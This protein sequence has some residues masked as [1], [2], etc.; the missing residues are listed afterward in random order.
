MAIKVT[1][2]CDGCYAE[3][4]DYHLSKCLAV[5]TNIVSDG[6]AAELTFRPWSDGLAKNSDRLH[7]HSDMCAKTYL[8][9]WLIK[10]QI[11]ASKREAEAEANQPAESAALHQLVER[12]RSK[13]SIPV[14]DAAMKA[15]EALS[16]FQSKTWTPRPQRF[17]TH[18]RLTTAIQF[19]RA[20]RSGQAVRLK[21][22]GQG[23]GENLT[24]EV[25]LPCKVLPLVDPIQRQS[26]E[27]VLTGAGELV[28]HIR[29]QRAPSD[30]AVGKTALGF[31]CAQ[32]SGDKY[33]TSIHI[34]VPRASVTN[35]REK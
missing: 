18:I 21:G 33:L 28:P 5:E 32:N 16:G 23:S 4:K 35:R 14:Q 6:S 10:Q 24:V 9:D 30:D 11:A 1:Q 2:T 25:R 8:Q 12:P 15:T 7:F 3:I 26:A 19:E 22:R 20:T 29:R 31:R 34:G 17:R 13:G 27:R